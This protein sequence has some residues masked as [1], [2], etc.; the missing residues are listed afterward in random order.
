MARW[1]GRPAGAS[2]VAGERPSE[3][4]FTRRD[5]GGMAGFGFTG[6]LVASVTASKSGLSV[7]G[8][9]MDKGV[10]SGAGD[11]ET[12]PG[13]ETRFQRRDTVA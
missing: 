11:S 6:V 7:N 3:L 8:M 10:E 13:S 5:C 12:G 2:R 4:T 1:N 9:R